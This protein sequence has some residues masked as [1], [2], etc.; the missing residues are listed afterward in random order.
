MRYIRLL[1]LLWLL[2]LAWADAVLVRRKPFSTRYAHIQF[3]CRSLM[4]SLGIS[5]R[6][7]GE[8]PA[9]EDQPIL[10]VS[11]HQSFFDL[12]MLEAGIPIPFTF[13][14]KVQNGRIPFLRSWAKTLDLIYFDR[15]D[16]GSAVHMLRESTRRLKKG[17]HILI[18]PEGTRSHQAAMNPLMAGSL[19][20]AK[21]SHAWIVPIVLKNSYAY[22]T[23]WKNGFPAQMTILNPLTYEQ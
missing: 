5:L 13:I 14:S 22:K 1:H 16:Q 17:K 19:Q 11:N 6:V 12:V 4:K 7:E 8:I 3:W 10:F 20:P 9:F 23:L 15:D 21:L 18:F 2:P